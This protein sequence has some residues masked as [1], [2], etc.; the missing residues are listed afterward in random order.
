[1][2]SELAPVTA[3]QPTHTY[4]TP[5][6]P[7]CGSWLACDGGCQTATGAADIYRGFVIELKP[8]TS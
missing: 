4:L 2:A 7:K 6:G 8:A 5:H 1:M 3:P